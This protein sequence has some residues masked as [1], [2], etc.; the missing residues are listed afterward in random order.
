[1]FTQLVPSAQTEIPLVDTSPAGTSASLTKAGEGTV[2]YSTAAVFSST[3]AL[4]LGNPVTP[5][6]LQIVIGSV[7]LTDTGGQ[8]FD[9]ATA[10]GNVDYARGFVTFAGLAAPYSGTKNITF[11]AAGA[12]LRV[13]DTGQIE[14]TAESRSFNYVTTVEPPPAPGSVMVSYRA[15][16]RWYDLV[17]N[18]SGVLRGSDSTYGT[19]T[20]NYATGSIAVTVGALPDVGS[21]VM[22]LWGTRNTLIDRSTMPI[23]PSG[24]QTTLPDAP[25]A[26][27][28]VDITWN[29]GTPRTAS[30]DGKG[31]ITGAATGTIDYDT[32]VLKFVVTTLPLGGQEY[33]INYGTPNGSDTHTVDFPAPTREVD[34]TLELDLGQTNITP[35]TVKLNYSLQGPSIDIDPSGSFQVVYTPP[36]RAFA[37]DDGNGNIIGEQ[38][39]VAGT[40]NYTTGIIRFQPDG[41]VVVR[42]EKQ[43]RRFLMYARDYTS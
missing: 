13:S 5:G 22:F 7:V 27:G 41:P 15:Q 33:E 42:A 18:G 2:S 17:D 3:T 40:I 24:V 28:S 11:K 34:L 25:I 36:P 8:V 14:V 19:G 1:M 23:P 43:L 26:P 37:K 16:G 21:S 9:S 38:N 4:T 29:D 20:V 12:P 31:V 39:R 35:G 30:D 6:T 32:G 10:I